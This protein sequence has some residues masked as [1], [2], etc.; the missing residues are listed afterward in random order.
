MFSSWVMKGAE[1]DT[2]RNVRETKEFTANL[3]SKFI[4]IGTHFFLNFL[5]IVSGEPW[6]HAANWAS[7]DAPSD[8]NE[9]IGAGL[10]MQKSVSVPFSF[11]MGTSKTSITLSY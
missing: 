6:V 10:T 3:I 2:S 1:K 8:I 4:A 5:W 11:G 7:L 9:W